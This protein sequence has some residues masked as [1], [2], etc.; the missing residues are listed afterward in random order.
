MLSPD[1]NRKGDVTS[2]GN[3]VLI[4]D[5]TRG[6]GGGQLGQDPLDIVGND[7]MLAVTKSFLPGP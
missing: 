6:A 2:L 4:V 3:Y 1:S 7:L 5:A